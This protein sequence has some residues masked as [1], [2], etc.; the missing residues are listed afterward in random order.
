[1]EK[2]RVS[3][4]ETSGGNSHFR[5]VLKRHMFSLFSDSTVIAQ[6]W[7]VKKNYVPNCQGDKQKQKIEGNKIHLALILK[8]THS[9]IHPIIF[10]NHGSYITLGTV[11]G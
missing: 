2:T 5:L 9:F 4:D 7:L 11:G 1:M 10:S 3:E 8:L 6:N